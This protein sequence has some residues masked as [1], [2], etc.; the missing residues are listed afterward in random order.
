MDDSTLR[1]REFHY[2]AGGARRAPC[3][4]KPPPSHALRG[5]GKFAKQVCHFVEARPQRLVRRTKKC[6]VA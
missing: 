6:L 5:R 2:T 4:L 1:D 3:D